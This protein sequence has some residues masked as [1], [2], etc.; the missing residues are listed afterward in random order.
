[1]KHRLYLCII[2]SNGT[3][4]QYL[5]EFPTVTQAKHALFRAISEII[6]NTWYD[7]PTTW[8]RLVTERFLAKIPATKS[9]FSFT[10]RYEIERLDGHSFRV[11]DHSHS[12]PPHSTYYIT[13]KPPP[14]REW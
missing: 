11:Y 1:M 2:P 5:E 8:Q 13:N 3:P 4:D 7:I 10:G 14:E 9:T 12:I 6:L